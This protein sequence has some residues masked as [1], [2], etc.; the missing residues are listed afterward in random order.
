MIKKRYKDIDLKIFVFNGNARLDTVGYVSEFR[1]NF[2]KILEVDSRFTHIDKMLR[3]RDA[4]IFNTTSYSYST[5][6]CTIVL[7]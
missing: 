6:S 5:D 4:V 3:P 1:A 2:G 7:D